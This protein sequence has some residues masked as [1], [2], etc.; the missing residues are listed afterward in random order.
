MIIEIIDKSKYRIIQENVDFVKGSADRVWAEI[1][2][3]T[4]FTMFA[5]PDIIK[6]VH[7]L[8][9]SLIHI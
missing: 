6:L 1:A 4:G 7:G 2:P 3:Q 8:F 9:L 5:Y